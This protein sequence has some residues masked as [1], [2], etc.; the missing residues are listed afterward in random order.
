[1]KG[2]LYIY[3]V[4][5]RVQVSQMVVWRGNCERV[6]NSWGLS[7]FSHSFNHKETKYSVFGCLV[8]V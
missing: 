3:M 6:V 5:G 7:V 8:E 4:V 1:M 2:T